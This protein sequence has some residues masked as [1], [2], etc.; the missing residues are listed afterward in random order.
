MSD[1]ETQIDKYKYDQDLP[2]NMKAWDNEVFSNKPIVQTFRDQLD[3]ARPSP[4]VK[5]WE[6]IGDLIKAALQQITIGGADIKEQMEEV[7]TGADS[8]LAE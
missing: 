5:S 6:S 4:F 7:N 3:T 2:A 8:L 1:P